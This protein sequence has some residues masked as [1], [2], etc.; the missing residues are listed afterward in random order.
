MSNLFKPDKTAQRLAAEQARK[1][2]ERQAKIREGTKA[3]DTVFGEQFNNKFYNGRQ[4][5]YLDYAVPQLRQQFEDA[6]KELTFALDRSGTLDSTIRAQKEA[7]LQKKYDTNLQGVRDQALTY[8]TQA[9]SSVEDARTNLIQMLNATGD[10]E[11][12]I[13]AAMAR[14]N[15][16]SQQPQFNPLTNLFADFTSALGTQAAAE[17]SQMMSGGTVKA[18]YNTGLF[19]GGRVSVTG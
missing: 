2:A 14:S 15:A 19:G 7:E 3:V 1:E 13:N 4:Q 6:R 16:L 17:R 12:A 5:S 9:Q 11:G 8:R 18:P 10:A